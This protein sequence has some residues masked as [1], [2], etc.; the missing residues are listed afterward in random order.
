MLKLDLKKEPFW[1]DLQADARVKVKP[2]NSALMNMAQADAVRA[3]LAVQAE[4][5]ARLDAGVDTSDLPD[6]DN[7]RV[8]HSLSETALITA[9]ATHAIIAWENVMKPEGGDLA[10]LNRENVIDLMDIWFVNQEFGK[11]YMRQ[12]DL[13]ETEGN[14]LRPVA[15]GTSAA[16]RATAGRARK[17]TSRAA[18]VKPAH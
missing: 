10:E 5:K 9:L 4:R 17:K 14:A 15:N 11:K 8:R 2:L 1:I 7:E 12:L 16:G 13:L 3:M 6:L 18:G